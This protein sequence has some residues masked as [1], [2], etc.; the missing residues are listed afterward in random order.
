MSDERSVGARRNNQLDPRIPI[1]GTTNVRDVGG[2]P[3]G[4]G[5][6]TAMGRLYRSE[7][8]GLSGSGAESLW[9]ELR[10]EDYQCLR[11]R[12][13][14]DLR[15]H[16]EARMIPSAWDRATGAQLFHAPIPEGVEGSETDFMRL[17]RD[18]K[19]TT[20]DEEDLGRWYQM[21]LRRRTDVLGEVI[22]V[23]SNPHHLPALVHCHAGKDRTGLVVALVLEVVGV[24]RNVVTADYALTSK[25]RPDRAAEHAALLEHLGIHVDDVRSLWEAPA[26]AM[27][28]ALEFLDIT[29]GGVAAYLTN[30]CSVT[31]A[32]IE[33][34]RA[35]MLED[36]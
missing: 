24:P 35:Q 8:L 14:V 15:S 13:I 25:Y 10:T 29:Y 36:A 18:G 16:R 27:E 12:S 9:D 30:E 28:S 32:H 19:I 33:S 34:L 20:F 11:L 4:D 26:R 21:V 22:R 7:V 17:L 3:T 23:L 5:K 31:P 1:P 2:Y 6:R